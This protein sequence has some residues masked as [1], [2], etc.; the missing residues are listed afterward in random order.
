M[1][2]LSQTRTIYLVE[3]KNEKNT[4]KN[5][6]FYVFQEAISFS[7]FIESARTVLIRESQENI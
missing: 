6:K 7:N 1:K 5:K 3:W 4:W 2:K